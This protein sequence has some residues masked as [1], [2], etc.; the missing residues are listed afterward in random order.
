MNRIAYLKQAEDGTHEFSYWDLY[1]QFHERYS[2]EEISTRLLEI[3]F[4]P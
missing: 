1:E 3:E 2:A 4:S